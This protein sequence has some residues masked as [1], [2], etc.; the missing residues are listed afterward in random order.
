MAF[1]SSPSEVE[2]GKKGTDSRSYFFDSHFVGDLSSINK[3]RGREVPHTYY[4]IQKYTYLSLEWIDR[5]LFIYSY[6][7]IYIDISIY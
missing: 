3:G 4:D 5:Y 6:V 2:A 7:D 1:I